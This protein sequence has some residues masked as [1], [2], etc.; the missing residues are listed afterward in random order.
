MPNKAAQTEAAP[1]QSAVILAFDPITRRSDRRR[2]AEAQARRRQR[3]ADRKQRQAEA[4]SLGLAVDAF[5]ADEAAF[6]HYEAI[7]ELEAAYEQ[8]PNQGRRALL[9]ILGRYFAQGH[10]MGVDDAQT[11]MRQQII[12]AARFRG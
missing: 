4:E 2:Q 5:E 1:Q 7:R 8:G 10:E 9:D 11:D 6:Y 3:Q 12:A